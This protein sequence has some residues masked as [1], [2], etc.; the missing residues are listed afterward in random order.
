LMWRPWYVL[1]DTFTPRAALLPMIALTLVP[2]GLL[3]RLTAAVLDEVMASDYVRTARSKGVPEWRVI[4]GHAL[5]NAMPRIL[6]GFPGALSLTVSSM[7]VVERLTNWPGIVKWVVPNFYRE[8]D[9]IMK[10]LWS[11]PTP[12]VV[13]IVILLLVTCSIVLETGVQSL[14]IWVYRDHREGEA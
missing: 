7:L 10:G 1:A 2:L 8:P 4:L 3:A 6:A 13:A 14:S 9:G 5:K 12:Q 11:G